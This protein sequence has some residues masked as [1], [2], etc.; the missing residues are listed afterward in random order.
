MTS[1]TRQAT[2]LTVLPYL[3]TAQDGRVRLLATHCPSCGYNTFPPSTVCPQCMSLDVQPLPLNRTGT[4]YSF[5]TIRHGSGHTYAGC[6][7]FPEKVRVFG[8]LHGFSAD[9]PPV[10]DMQV[11]IVP[12][13]PVE[14]ART[15]APVDFNFQAANA[16][17]EAAR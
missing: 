16:A 13:G 1:E 8:H 11:A 15:S 3:E 10:C 14:G 12:A 6:V 4:L 2:A 17:A 7:D 5:T 9:A